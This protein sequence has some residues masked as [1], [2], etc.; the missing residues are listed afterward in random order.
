MKSITLLLTF[1]LIQSLH[2][3][4]FNIMDLGAKPDGT[5]LCTDL[6]QKAID[7]CS[8]SG[9]G[10]VTIP[11]GVFLTGTIFLKN[12]VILNLERGAVLLGSTKIED[13]KPGSIIRALKV[14]NIGITGNGSIDGQGHFW[15]DPADKNATRYAGILVGR[16]VPAWIHKSPN[17][18]NLIQFEGCKN[19]IIEN[20]TLKGSE[21]W[22]LHLLACD[23]VLVSGIKIRN[24]LHG[25]NT[26]GI[27]IQA[28]SNLRISGCDIYTRDDAI[29]IKNRHPE[30]FGKVCEN[31]TVTNCILSTVCNGFKI[32]TE[33]LSDFRNIVF[34]N[35]V[36]YTAKPD[37]EL[38]KIA[39]TYVN[40]DYYRIGLA[41]S[42]GISIE[43]VD[44]ANVYGITITNIVIDGPWTP[45]FIRLGNRGAGEQKVAVPV[46]GTLKDV[47]ISNI[48]AYGASIA[49]SITAIPG[50]YV[51]NVMLKNILI[52]TQGGGDKE[53]AN[54]ILDEEIKTYPDTKMWGPMPVSGFFIRHVKGLQMSDIKIDV[55]EN[56]MRPLIKFDDVRDLYINNLQTNEAHKGDCIL[57]FKNVKRANLI[58]F[59]FPEAIKIPWLFFKG[60]ETEKIIVRTF[61]NIQSKS[62]IKTD[63]TVRENAVKNISGAN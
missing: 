58:N 1:C 50:S 39:A 23:E 60:N 37:D 51:E 33:S 18:G 15:W 20:V 10:T 29:V 19:V 13:Y 52:R 32:G 25:P 49:S 34:S 40:P 7:N 26:D 4:N 24:P 16:G 3:K 44:G 17:P 46:P 21:S 22:T 36:I 27:D 53:L 55:S 45:I 14:Q 57:D 47:I 42:S 59:D 28:C 12:N 43:T 11:T 41:A 54:K 31:I 2:A 62:F 9:G 38:A 63:N 6:I 30:Y 8:V 5:T 56:D 48:V 61:D 35:S